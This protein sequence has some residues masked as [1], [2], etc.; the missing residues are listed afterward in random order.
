VTLAS[1]PTRKRRRTDGCF[2]FQLEGVVVLVDR[3]TYDGEDAI[4]GMVRAH[5][6]QF[7]GT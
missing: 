3:E 1:S 7:A 5:G 6:G 4:I 2:P